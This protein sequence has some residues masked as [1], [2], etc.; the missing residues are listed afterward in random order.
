VGSLGARHRIAKQEE[1]DML[2][3]IG[4]GRSGKAVLLLALFLGLISAVLV[5]VYLSQAGG[6]ETAAS[7]ETKPVLV[8]K[9]DIPVA[10]RIT[11][12]MVETKAIPADVVL[13][14]SFSS[15][16][17]VVGNMARYPIAAGEQIL[18]ERVASGSMSLPEGQELPLPYIVPEGKRAVSATTSALIGVGGLVR[19]GDYVDVIVTAKLQSGDQIGRIILQNLEVLALDQEMEKVAPKVEESTQA[20]T[21]AAEGETNPE[22]VTVTLA[23][24]PVEGEVLTVA[25]ECANNFGGR[26]ALALRPFGEHDT[27][28]VRPTWSETGSTP[29]CSQLFGVGLTDLTGSPGGSQP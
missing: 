26:L 16:E 6:E 29:L 14:G 9:E 8:A 27:V 15:T 12:S 7:G 20:Q 28:E 18:S 1:L 5:Y 24:T 21:A 3:R 4:G 23:V 13:P 17:G 22:A 10:T 19:P 2:N 11:E 25:E